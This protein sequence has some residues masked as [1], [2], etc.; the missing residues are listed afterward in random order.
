MH[1]ATHKLTAT[2]ISKAKPK[3]KPSKLSDGHGLF[4]YVAPTGGKLWRWSYRFNGAMKL[5]SFGPYPEITL[6]RARELHMSA[7]RTLL[8]GIDPMVQKK[9]EKLQKRAEQEPTLQ[10]AVNTFR[11]VE[12][13][14]HEKWRA[15]KTKRHAEQVQNRIDTDILSK[16]GDRPIADIEPMEIV[17]VAK[18]IEERG[19]GDL[20]HRSIGTM[21][22]IF[23][24]AVANGFAKRNPVS[25]VKPRDILKEVA[26]HN[27]ARIDQ[28]ELPDLMRGIE[29]YYGTAIT[30]FAL[31]LI[32]Y[33]FVRTSEL[34]EAPWSEFDLDNA[35]WVIPAERMKVPTPHIVPLAHQAVECLRT[36]H[37]FSSDTPW[38]FPGE[39]DRRQTMSN[40]TI[41]KALERLGFKGEMTGHGFRGLASTILHEQGYKHEHIELQ[42]AHMKRDKVDAAYN[43]AKYMPA[44]TKMMQ[45][46][47]DFLDQQ[48]LGTC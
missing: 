3:V 45:E 42:L 36:L 8:T 9:E 19:C 13:K 46:W 47:A 34:I 21:G 48:R 40:N 10:A 27:F 4:L 43:Y 44:R 24:F 33:T 39:R 18:A 1:V 16:L 22:Q 14:W 11:E 32:A 20:A 31:K 23:R 37:G 17:E 30:R 15:G 41:L 5:M 25:D 35:R 7:R 29:F 26:E 12:A 38:L 28:K 2:Q 6:E